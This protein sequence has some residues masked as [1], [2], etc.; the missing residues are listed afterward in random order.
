MSIDEL[1]VAAAA[2][3][4]VHGQNEQ[5]SGIGGGI[6]IRKFFEPGHQGCG[7]R[8]L[9]LDLS[10]VTL[11]FADE[12]ECS[13]CIGEVSDCIESE[14]GPEGVAAEKP[15]EARTRAV[16]GSAIAGDQT[17]PQERIVYQSLNHA[18]AGPVISRLDLFVGKIHRDRSVQKI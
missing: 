14:I 15:C 16:T 4:I 11:I 9:M 10:I 8:N 6:R 1:D 3:V 2:D 17:R 12:L 13:A 18:D 5:R 7:L